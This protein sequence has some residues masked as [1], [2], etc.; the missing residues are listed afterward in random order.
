MSNKKSAFGSFLSF[1][2]GNFIVLL[3]GFVQ[4][5]IVTRLMST[6]EYGR[7]GMFE[8]A[9]SCIYIF[10][11]LGLDQSF[12]RYYYK[13]N[14]DRDYLMRSCL[15]TTL[16]IVAGLIVIYLFTADYVNYWLFK[17]NTSLDV[18]ILVIGYTVISVFE[19]FLFL[20]VRMQQNGKLYSNI[21]ISQKVLNILL[22]FGTAWFLGN[23]FRVALYAMT[24]SWGITTLFLGVRYFLIRTGKIKPVVNGEVLTNGTEKV[25]II[26]LIKYG[27]PFIMVLLMEWL[28]SS[29]DSIALKTWADYNELGIYRAAVKIIVLLVTF[30][31]TFLAYWSPVAMERYETG[32]EEETKAFF[33]QAF[34]IVR[35]FCVLAAIALIMFRQVIVLLLGAKY[36][37]ADKIIPFLTLMP[38]FAMMFEITV[39]G[40][41]FQKK[42]MYLNI[43]SA[44]T[45]VC[46]ICGNAILVPRLAGVGAAITTGLS[47]IIYFAIGSFFSER[48]YRVRYDFIRTAVD[49]ILLVILA[50]A[51]SF[52]D[53]IVITTVMAIGLI[54][55]VCIIERDSLILSFNYGLSV[56]QKFIRR[57]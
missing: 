11:I 7:A 27:Y 18:T 49:G 10:A 54:L 14:I 21:N 5:P 40:I 47:Y 9:V 50:F 37:G 2:Y 45:I 53:S 16:M 35:F 46:N 52:I 36:R 43:A 39:Q 24:V 48:V 38:I 6:D 19:R 55:A 4:T 22:I 13:K 15:K 26:E 56:L 32:K 44:V 33:R 57:K 41:K 51:A 42:N 8:A 20:D 3:L 25:S 34:R 17:R 1:F 30:K 12:I 23:D 29:C 28:L 31:N